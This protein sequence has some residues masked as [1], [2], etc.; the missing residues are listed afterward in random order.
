MGKSK[1]LDWDHVTIIRADASG[2]ERWGMSRPDLGVSGGSFIPSLAEGNNYK[3]VNKSTLDYT[4]KLF[5]NLI[6]AL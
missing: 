1:G 5:Y 4:K 6:V 2:Q 3:L